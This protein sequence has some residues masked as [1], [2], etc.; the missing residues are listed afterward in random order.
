M[1]VPDILQASEWS[2]VLCSIEA[3]NPSNSF[4]PSHLP[5]SMTNH[6]L[7][8]A[9]PT[10]DVAAAFLASSLSTSSGVLVRNCSAWMPPGRSSSSFSSA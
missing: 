6:V 1:T 3:I 10:P 7:T 9:P 8:H 2:G 5:Q 4:D